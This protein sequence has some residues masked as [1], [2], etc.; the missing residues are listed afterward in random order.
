MA[1]DQ[2]IQ[3]I[4]KQEEQRGKKRPADISPLRRRM[5]LQ[6]EFKE[7]LESNDEAAFI[8]AIVNDLAQ[9]AGSPEYEKSLKIWRE[10]RGRR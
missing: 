2:E 1:D 7:A 8:Q 3:D 10:F 6:K 4:R 9:L 5:I